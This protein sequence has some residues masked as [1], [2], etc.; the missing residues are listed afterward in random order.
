MVTLPSFGPAPTALG[1]GRSS[2]RA[3]SNA[4][5][6]VASPRAG[7]AMNLY[8]ALKGDRVYTIYISTSI[9]HAS[10][11]FADPGSVAHPYAD[12]LKAPVPILTGLP[13]DLAHDKLVIRY[14]LDRNGSLR[15]PQVLHTSSG[16]FESKV[17]AAL[18]NWKFSP[19]LR[20]NEAVEV[21]VILGFGVD[22]K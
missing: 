19:A 8:G 4:I 12:E 18:A 10:M 3:G 15:N 7:G 2:T 14:V 20:G 13:A 6:V 22:T 17:L 16:D 11:Q 9:G 1:A 5:T 21:N